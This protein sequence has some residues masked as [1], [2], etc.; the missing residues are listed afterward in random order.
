MPEEIPVTYDNH[1]TFNLDVQFSFKA[2]IDSKGVKGIHERCLSDH[3]GMPQYLKELA[4]K[5]ESLVDG[6]P[7]NDFM[8]AVI[9]T[10]LRD[11]LYELM[12]EELIG[13]LS[14]CVRTTNLS[15]VKITVTPKK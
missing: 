12:Q 15:P 7:T 4:S 1:K 13:Q 3:R 2:I 8:S 10:L 9:K 11:G 14:E 6:E 5:P